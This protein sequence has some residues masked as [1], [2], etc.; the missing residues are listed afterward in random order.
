MEG[1]TGC[2]VSHSIFDRYGKKVASAIAV[3]ANSAGCQSV[4]ALSVKSPELW[5]CDTPTLYTLLTQVKDSRGR[6]VDE[7]ETSFG[8]RDIRFEANTGFYLNGK[9]MKLKGMCLHQDV[10]SLG[11]AVPDEMW[12]RRLKAMKEIGCNAIRCSHNPPSPEF[13][14]ICDTLGLLVLDE[15][16]DKWKS[17]Y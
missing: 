5:S 16:F 12:E 6:L 7:V 1:D 2:R 8:F 10:G 4:A 3:K 14:T 13:L 9:N 17:G 11:V 15:A